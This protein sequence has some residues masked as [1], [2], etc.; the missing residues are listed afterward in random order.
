[1]NGFDAP[2]GSVGLRF[3][4]QYYFKDAANKKPLKVSAT[5]NILT[6]VLSV[7]QTEDEKNSS[8]CLRLTTV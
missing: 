8:L 1:M 3:S 2:S 5:N 4:Y 6:R 7:K